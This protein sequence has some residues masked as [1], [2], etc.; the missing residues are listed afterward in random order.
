MRIFS[1]ALAS[2]LASVEDAGVRESVRR[3]LTKR[4]Y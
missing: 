2:V 1:R 4:T 3:E